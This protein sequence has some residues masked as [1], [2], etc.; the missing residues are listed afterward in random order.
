MK[1]RDPLRNVRLCQ[2]G[3]LGLVNCRSGGTAPTARRARRGSRRLAF[4]YGQPGIEIVRPFV[5]RKC[6]IAYGSRPRAVVGDLRA[7]TGG[8]QRSQDMDCLICGANA[9][10]ILTTID[11]MTVVCPT[12]G[13]YDVESTVATTGLMQKLEPE[14]RRDVLDKAKRSAAPG[15]T[16]GPLLTPIWGPGCWL[17]HGLATVTSRTRRLYPSIY[18]G[19]VP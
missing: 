19:R 14:Q 9:E 8:S 6:R 12:C 2:L 13:E 11:D 1:G 16:P 7:F 17:R 10:Q 15:A 5:P 4:A 18:R 3:S